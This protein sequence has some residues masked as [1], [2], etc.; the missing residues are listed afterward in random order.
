MF[1]FRDEVMYDDLTKSGTVGGFD[2]N[3]I[4]IFNK[5]RKVIRISNDVFKKSEFIGNGHWDLMTVEDRR[6][7]LTK[8]NVSQN[9]IQYDW[10]RIPAIIQDKIQKDGT[11]AGT[12]I[13]TSTSGVWNPVNSDKTVDQKLKETK[14]KNEEK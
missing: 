6:D 4:Q 7:I 10:A 9:Y 5:G 8:S 3:Y 12:G 13:S 1:N 2:G 11:P 14:E